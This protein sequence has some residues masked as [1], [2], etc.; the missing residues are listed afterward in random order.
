MNAAPGS[1]GLAP[2]WTSSSKDLVTTAAEGTSRVWLTLGHGIGNE[3]YWPSTGEPQVRDVGFIVVSQGGWTEIKRANTY[4]LTL[5]APGVLQPTTVHRGDDWVLTLRWSVDPDRD[6]VVIEYE[7]DGDADGLYLLVAPH[8]GGGTTPNSGWVDRDRLVARADGASAALCTMAVPGFLRCSVGF[9]GTSDGWQDL[10]TNGAMTWAYDSAHG[11]NVALTAELPRPRGAI[12]IG[13]ATTTEGAATLAASTLAA[14]PDHVR[15]RFVAGWRLVSERVDTSGVDPR[16]RSLTA[17]S[18]SVIACHEDRTYPGAT[19]ASLSIPWGNDRNDLGGYHLVWARDC[20]E[21]AFARLAVGD[22]TAARRTLGWLCA[23]QQP[24]GHWTQNAYPD[25]RPFW[26]GIQLDETALPILLAAAL[27]IDTDDATVAAMVRAAVGF[28]VTHGPASPQ[29]RWEENAGTNAFTLA[30]VVAALIASRRWLTSD[31]SAYVTSLADYWNERIEDW[32]YVRGEL[33]DGRAINGYYVRLGSTDDRPGHRGRIDVRNRNGLH[34]DAD[35]LIALDFLA[36]P[37]FGLR[38]PDDPRIVDTV[39]LVDELLAVE[40]PTGIAYRRYN[41]DGYGEHDDGS[42][43]DGTGVGRP[44][45]LLAGER[46]HYAAQTGEDPAPFLTSMSAMTGPGGLL[47]EQVWD[48]GPIPERFLEPGRPTGSA[49]PLV[50]AH[51]EFVK[52]ATYQ[53][54]GRPVERLA[55]VADRYLGEST[56]TGPWHWRLDAPFATAPSGRSVVIDHGEPFTFSAEETTRR[57][58]P[59]EFGRHVLDIEPVA[60]PLHFELRGADGTV[61]GA[62]QLTWS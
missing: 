33:C 5:P 25:N 3:I 44:W 40:L 13:L 19:V 39:A 54:R 1:P 8:L 27:E 43:F 62:G 22:A 53:R 60:Q 36:L 37:R 48:A 24:D 47:P 7:L 34:V 51:A 6:A 15:D 23:T 31:E 52:L 58:G 10:D 56:P 11:G 61:I 38:R 20:V 4:D 55:E 46:G 14:G 45:P 16:W 35:R 9:V 57:S 32:L 49:M 2:T 50:W 30:T 12:A 26:T 41:G 17:M 59:S 29:D 21:T 18:A 42:P 28:L